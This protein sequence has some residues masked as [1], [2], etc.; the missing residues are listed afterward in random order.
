MAG[1][2]RIHIGTSGW[3]YKHW[4]GLYYPAGLRPAHY[5]RFY[6]KQFKTAEINTSFY[7]LPKETSLQ[8]WLAEVPEDFVFCPK[9]SRFLSHMKKLHDAQEPVDRFC[10]LFDEIN[11]RLGPVLI[12]LP[13]TLRFNA[14]VTKAFYQILKTKKDFR[15]AMEVRHESW[16]SDESLFLMKT[17][18]ISLVFAQSLYYPYLEVPTAPDIYLRLHGPGQLYASAYDDEC[19]AEYAR[20]LKK[21]ESEGYN[22][23][24]FFNNDVYGYAYQNAG[25]LLDLTSAS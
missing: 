16:F 10:S 14:D 25:L 5:L 18:S 17:F 2:N 4:A 21:W 22:V 3:S 12:Q 13:D 1:E 20:K 9:M 8:N 19:L 24:I 6:S 15:F 7:R 23:W 11:H